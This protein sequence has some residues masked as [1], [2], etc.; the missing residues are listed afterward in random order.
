MSTKGQTQT[1]LD[2]PAGSVADQESGMLCEQCG[3]QGWYMDGP[4]E[5]PQ[6]RQCENCY[7]TGRTEERQPP[8]NI[9]VRDGED[10]AS[11]SPAT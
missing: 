1:A 5:D 8:Q 6:Q 11:H 2:V 9:P 3:G 4:P 10:R 7:G